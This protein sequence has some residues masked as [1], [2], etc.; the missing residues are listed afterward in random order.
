[1]ALRLKRRGID[2]VRPLEGGYGGWVSEGYPLQ[3]WA[4]AESTST[5][6]PV[7]A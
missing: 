3:Q 2:R 7:G 6:V 1:M 4:P 5:S